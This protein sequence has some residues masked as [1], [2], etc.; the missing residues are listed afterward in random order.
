MGYKSHKEFQKKTKWCWK[1][2]PVIDKPKSRDRLIFSDAT[3]IHHDNCFLVARNEKHTVAYHW[4]NS[5]NKESYRQLFK[6]IKPP[7]FVII[8]GNKSCINAI[9]SLHSD[10]KI[11]RC[12]F[13]I[14][15]FIRQK[16]SLHPKTECGIELLGLAKYLFKVKTRTDAENW[17]RDYILWEHKYWDF[18]SQKSYSDDKKSSWYTHKNIRSCRFHIR[19]VLK[20]KSLFRYIQYCLPITNNYIEGGINARLK[21]LKRCHRGLNLSK[22]KRMFEW[23][24]WRRSENPD[25]EKLFENWV[26]KNTLFAL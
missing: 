19:S 1:I 7:Q 15:S 10:I 16:L 22:Q 9:K 3:F 5:E 14:F 11:Q 4:A 13:H 25:L 8:D 24:A 2:K 21:E 23:Y 26:K 20:S 12:L 18:L 17:I 6:Q